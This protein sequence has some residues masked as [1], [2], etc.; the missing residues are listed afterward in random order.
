MMRRAKRAK[1]GARRSARGVRQRPRGPREKILSLRR[2]V[3]VVA[4]LKR[5]GRTVVF[6]NGVFDLLH[7]GHVALLEKAASLGDVLVVGVNADGSVRRLKGEGR[8]IVPLAERME[9][10]AGLRSVDH[11]V[12]FTEPTPARIIA[13]LRPDI[14]VKG[15][16]YRKSEIV[17]RDTVE[18]GGGRVVTVP[19][20]RGRSSTDLIRR[21][22]AAVR[23]SSGDRRR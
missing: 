5:R 2:A 16:D 11:V 3:P 8:P 15:G 9:M 13:R 17:G 19:L 6:T 22:L 14:L 4:S 7:V 23:A 10:L 18:S 21:A 20:R 12:S 1:E